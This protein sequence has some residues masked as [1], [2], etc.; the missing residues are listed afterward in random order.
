MPGIDE[1]VASMNK[2]YKTN[3]IRKA[4]ELKSVEFIP[5]TSPKMNYLTRGGAPIGRM[6]ELV[7]LPQSGKTT[8]ALDLLANYQKLFPERFSVY[9]DA[10]NTLDKDWGETIGVNWDNVILIQPESEYGEDLLDMTLDYIR[11][12]EVG[13][14]VLDSAPFI[15]PKGIAEKG[16]EEKSY[17]GNSALM[18]AFCDKV[19]PLCKKHECTFLMLNQLRENIGNMYKPYKIPCGTALTHACSQ[20]L[21]FTKGSLLDENGDEKSSTYPNPVGNVVN[22]RVEKNKV[23]KND[24]RLDSY[25][26]NYFRGVDDGT[27]T[28]DLGIML[29]VIVKSGGWYN[30]PVSDGATK[31][32]QG[33]EKVLD[34]FYNDLDEFEWLKT[35]VNKAAMV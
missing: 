1:L 25:T 11:S 18:K 16:L 28:I 31:K 7:G 20:I 24:R 2:K 5:Y 17:G 14:S 12:G 21:W 30:I 10:E 34:Y 3:I 9:L 15:V 23:T 8:T 33:R 35:M 27:D 26:L 4:S 13:M 29:N 6:I 22:V 32:V 19:I